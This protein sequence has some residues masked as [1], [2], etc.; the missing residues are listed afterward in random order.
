MQFTNAAIDQES[1]PRIEDVP[2]TPVQ[3]SYLTVLRIEWL[4]TSIIL[5]LIATI[6][7]YFIPALQQLLGFSIITAS[8]LIIVAFYRFMLEKNFPFHAYAI[9]EKDVI[10][11]RGWIMRTVKISP[12]NRIQNC[13]V[14][15]GP[16]ER[17]YGLASLIIYTAGSDQADMRIPGLMQEE[18]ERLRHY[19]L[20][21][22]HAE[23]HEE[24]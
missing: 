4:L 21:K 13:S 8:A 7:V 2:L 22:I 11:Q 14:Q 17:K 1:L 6:L 19:I 23:D 10:S 3:R 18:A 24:L 20:Q 16:L 15:S 9:R 5:L 12:N